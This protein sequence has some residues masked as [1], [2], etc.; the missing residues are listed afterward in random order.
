MTYKGLVF[1]I[2]KQLVQLN[3]KTP[4]NAIKKVA[5]DL[6]RHAFKDIQIANG[7]MKI[8]PKSP[9]IREIQIKTTM[10]LHWSKW[11]S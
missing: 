8:S 11:S 5:E 3:N 7:H 6:N 9:I 2:H 1:K 10:T 4:N